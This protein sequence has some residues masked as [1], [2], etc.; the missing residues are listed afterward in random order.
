MNRIYKTIGIVLFVL[1]AIVIIVV[2]SSEQ[3]AL[4]DNEAVVENPFYTELRT[5]VEYLN[6]RV[7][8]KKL[9][10]GIMIEIRANS[11]ANNIE[12]DQASDLKNL[13][14]LYYIDKL[15]DATRLFFRGAC[16][17]LS[18]LAALNRELIRLYDD[19]RYSQNVNEMRRATSKV[20]QLLGYNRG[21]E[22]RGWTNEVKRFINGDYDEEREEY[23]REHIL[24]FLDKPLLGN[25][26]I[27][28][29]SVQDNI[30]KL[31]LAYLNHLDEK[32]LALVHSEDFDAEIA[33]G[34]QQNLREFLGRPY[35]D[36][37]ELIEKTVENILFKLNDG[38]YLYIENKVEDYVLDT[39]F[40]ETYTY[41]LY[42]EIEHYRNMRYIS[43]I[44]WVDSRADSLVMILYKHEQRIRQ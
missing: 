10:D 1:T 23:L 37:R 33:Q 39:V 5:Q 2:L 22:Q 36:D 13:A 35:L 26:A 7:W 34:I 19:K 32:V 6:E 18:Q 9:Y 44:D 41:T 12:K 20:Y 30:I 3:G 43:D 27:V 17:D 14:T 40:N 42:N 8:D 25:C 28:V 21:S 15:N 38:H 31:N 24:E 4:G 16:D 29:E 11:D